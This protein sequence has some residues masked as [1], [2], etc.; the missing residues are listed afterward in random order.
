MSLNTKLEHLINE[1]KE[2]EEWYC[3]QVPEEFH[4]WTDKNKWKNI[5][6]YN[7][8]PICITI[9]GQASTNTSIPARF[10]KKRPKILTCGCEIIG[11]H[12]LSQRQSFN[13]RIRIDSTIEINN[14]LS[15]LANEYRIESFDIKR[16]DIVGEKNSILTC[17]RHNPDGQGSSLYITAFL[18]DGKS[19][20]Y[21]NIS[22]SIMMSH[23]GDFKNK[24]AQC[25]LKQV[26]DH[27][28]MI[29]DSKKHKRTQV[30]LKKKIPI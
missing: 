14:A 6:E 17:V 4:I 27:G 7:V 22:L 24:I 20:L 10:T 3:F 21:P 9:Q 19:V 26:L 28:C 5:E 11:Q 15:E 29:K 2:G 16:M 25:Y 30:K 18:I 1:K 13:G 12:T 8:K 23:V